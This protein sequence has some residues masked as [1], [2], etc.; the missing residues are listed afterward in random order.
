MIRT[1][2]DVCEKEIPAESSV[3]SSF[4]VTDGE[5]PHSGSAMFKQVDVCEACRDELLKK[6]IQEKLGQ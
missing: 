3:K 5:H 2:C 1:F 4:K 6:A